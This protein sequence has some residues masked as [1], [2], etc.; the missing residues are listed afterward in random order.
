M[1]S[2]KP[3]STIDRALFTPR[4]RSWVEPVVTLIGGL[5]GRIQMRLSRHR[6]E[7]RLMALAPTHDELLRERAEETASPSGTLDV[8]S[9]GLLP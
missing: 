6:Y 2:T 4:P 1:Q 9:R 5:P 7:A 8:T 3:F